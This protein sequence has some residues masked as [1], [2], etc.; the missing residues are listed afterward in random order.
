MAV[1][2]PLPSRFENHVPWGG[3]KVE[4]SV[5]SSVPPALAEV[6]HG[7][8]RSGCPAVFDCDSVLQSPIGKP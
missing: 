4:V 1:N 5:A 3:K 7:L 2:N 6:A 8:G